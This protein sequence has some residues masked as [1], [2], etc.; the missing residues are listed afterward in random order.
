M[1]RWPSPVRPESH[2]LARGRPVEGRER[3]VLIP[4]IGIKLIDLALVGV[5][6]V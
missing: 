5:G 2:D 1:R 6:L 4:F 3:G